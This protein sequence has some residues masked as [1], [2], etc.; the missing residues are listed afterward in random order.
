[1]CVKRELAHTPLTRAAL[2]SED[3][4]RL[5]ERSSRTTGGRFKMEHWL[6]MHT[7]RNAVMLIAAVVVVSGSVTGTLGGTDPVGTAAS[8]QETGPIVLAQYNPCPNGR[9]R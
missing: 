4:D 9:C 1:M 8:A 3:L 7:I 2:G 5:A 6:S